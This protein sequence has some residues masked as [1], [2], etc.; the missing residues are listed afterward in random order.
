MQGST[1]RV[2][3][4]DRARRQNASYATLLSIA[5]VL[6]VQLS[7]LQPGEDG[8]DRLLDGLL[9]VEA[10]DLVGL[11]GIVLERAG[12]CEVGGGFA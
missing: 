3:Q 11:V 6:G 1:G 10:D 7:E 9:D 2:L 12:R 4:R 5:G 8:L